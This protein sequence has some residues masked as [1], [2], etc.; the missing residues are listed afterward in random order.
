MIKSRYQLSP[1]RTV[2][3]PDP[4]GY[5]REYAGKSPCPAVK[6][7][8]SLE[9]G[10]SIPVKNTAGLFRRIPAKFRCFPA[11]T[12]RK[13]PEN[14]PIGILL[15]QDQRNYSEPAVSRPD[16]STWE[17]LIYLTTACSSAPV[18]RAF[19]LLYCMNIDFGLALA[20]SVLGFLTALVSNYDQQNYLITS[21]VDIII[22]L[23]CVVY[24]YSVWSD[25]HDSQNYEII[26]DIWA[27]SYILEV[28]TSDIYS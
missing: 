5:S 3:S 27:A 4:V 7:V 19:Y 28:L 20:I 21:P 24:L 23:F 16:C 10:S 25:Y 12:D 14:F 13:S 6:H 2:R 17:V 18:K 9:H 26:I 11:G 15:P 1:D 22:L 8:K